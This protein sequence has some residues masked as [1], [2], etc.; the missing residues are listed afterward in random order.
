MPKCLAKTKLRRSAV[1]EE[2]VKTKDESRLRK[3]S[4]SLEPGRPA[5]LNVPGHVDPRGHSLLSGREN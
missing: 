1:L 4:Q 5:A 3:A 2:I